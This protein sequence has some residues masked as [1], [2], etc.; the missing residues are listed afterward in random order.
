M[1]PLIPLFW[2]CADISSGFQSQSMELYLYLVE[3]Y[4]LLRFTSGATSADI[5]A[6]SMAAESISFMYLRPAE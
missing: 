3:A 5:L 4:M 2:I 6:V 1:G